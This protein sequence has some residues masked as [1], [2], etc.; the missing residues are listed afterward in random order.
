LAAHCGTTVESASRPI[1]QIAR[2]G[3]S[4]TVDRQRFEIL[5][6]QRPLTC[7]VR[8]QRSAAWQAAS[9]VSGKALT[10][11]NAGRSNAGQNDRKRREA[12]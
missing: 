9:D 6:F 7:P 3:E 1:R 4:R 8:I 12:R 2:N 10:L 5:N 11:L